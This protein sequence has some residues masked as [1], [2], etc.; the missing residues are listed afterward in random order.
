MIGPTHELV[1]MYLGLLVSTDYVIEGLPRL[2]VSKG[3]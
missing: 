2:I 1:Y 3:S